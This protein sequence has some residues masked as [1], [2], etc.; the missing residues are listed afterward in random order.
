MLRI[1]A[2]RHAWWFLR[3]LAGAALWRA[4]PLLRPAPLSWASVTVRPGAA[5]GS[6]LSLGAEIVVLGARARAVFRATR[7][8]ARQIA[9]HHVDVVVAHTPA[10]ATAADLPVVVLSQS[11]AHL[12]VPALDPLVDNPIGWVRAVPP[13]AAALGP[14][15]HLPPTAEATRIVDAR[16]RVGLRWIH[17]LEDVQAFHA[18]VVERAGELARLAANGVVVHLADRDARLRPYLGAA[19][20][21]PDAHRRPRR[22][23]PRRANRSSIRMRRAALRE[24]SLRSRARQICEAAGLPDPPRLPLVSILLATRRPALLPGVAGA[25]RATAVPQ[26]GV[27]P[28]DCT[29][30][31]S[32]R[33]NAYLEPGCRFPVE[34]RA[35]FRPPAAF[36]SVLNAAASAAS[37]GTLLAKMDDDDLYDAEHIWDLVLAHEYSGAQLI[38][39]G[40]EFIYLARSDRTVH[41]FREGGEQY[42]APG[43]G[44]LGGGAKL[45]SRHDLDRAGGWQRAAHNEDQVLIEN[46]IRA[47]GRIYRTHGSGFVLVRHGHRHD[48]EIDD[49]Y[50]LEHAE[51]VRRGWDPVLAGLADVPPPRMPSEPQAS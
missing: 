15:E 37:T 12:S 46:I 36:G 2:P 51:V 45:I 39:K 1:R 49:A 41:R 50:F 19:A 4:A 5:E 24:H 47:G 10:E 27:D 16:D 14:L 44:A 32:G 31:A 7:R 38:A 43:R 3:W 20:P 8:V 33:R 40:A 18:G 11:P 29:A 30:R 28:G 42:V 26:A 25:D 48:W 22:R 13:I 17:H 35:G 9:D 34:D 23:S 21:R 6:R